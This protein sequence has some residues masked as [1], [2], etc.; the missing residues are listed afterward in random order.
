MFL[1]REHRELL[2]DSMETVQEFQNKQ[3]LI[4]Y[5]QIAFG[6]Y[7]PIGIRDVTIEPYCYDERIG[8]DTHIVSLKGWGVFGFTDRKVE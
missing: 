4:D 1:Y 6:N 8:W 7:T 5:L 2:A 3:E